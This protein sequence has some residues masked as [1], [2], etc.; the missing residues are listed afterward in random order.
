MKATG[1]VRKVD[2]LHRLVIPQEMCTTMDINAGTPM[3]F[4]TEAGTII[5]KK[6]QPGCEFCNGMAKLRT[7]G[8]KQICG[9]CVEDM[10][11]LYREGRI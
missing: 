8:G 7:F 10:R 11:K 2:A 1:I 4:F 6:Y 5:L 9:H 3:E